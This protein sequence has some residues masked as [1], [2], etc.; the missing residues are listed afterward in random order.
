MKPRWNI[1][2]PLA[3]LAIVRTLMHVYRAYESAPRAEGAVW[4]VTLVIWVAVV[5]AKKVPKPFLT[6][7]LT[8]GLSGLFSAAIQ[9]LFWTRFWMTVQNFDTLAVD[10]FSP[11]VRTIAVGSSLVAGLLWGAATG[12]LA[13]AIGWL[14]YPKKTLKL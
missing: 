12:L 1:I 7:L 10:V 8:G 14:L 11:L 2:I 3:A 5:V 6:L 4:I 9:Q 13:A